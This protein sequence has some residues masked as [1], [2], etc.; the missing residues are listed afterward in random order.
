M[1]APRIDVCPDHSAQF[2]QAV[3]PEPDGVQEEMAAEAEARGDRFPG[4]GSFPTVGPTV[5]AWLYHLASRPDV[6]RVFEF[7]SGFGYSAYWLARGLSARG[8]LVLTERDGDELALARDFMER[9]GFS[10]TIQYEQ[11][12][13]LS[14][15]QETNGPFDLVVLDHKNDA[16]PAALERVRGRLSPGGILVADNVMTAAI[17][18]TEQLLAG[19]QSGELGAGN[20]HTRGEYEYLQAVRSD[21]AIH[22]QLVPIGGGLAVSHVHP[23]EKQ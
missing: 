22:T 1:T 4:E 14:T 13:A 9:G 12:D 15:F 8:H 21:P 10:A 7:G 6:E 11:G 18:Q 5:G 20:P 19:L 17:I 2:V 3:A 16:Y 23:D